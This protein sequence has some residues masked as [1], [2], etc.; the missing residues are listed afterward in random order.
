MKEN[1]NATMVAFTVLFST[2][3]F[4][5]TGSV[6]INTTTPD[7]SAVLDVESTTKGLLPP[8][9]TNDQMKAIVN[10]VD[11]LTVYNTTLKCLVTYINGSY[12][13]SYNAPVQAAP[14]APS[15]SSYTGFYNGITNEVSANNTAASY[16]TGVVFSA[17][18][19]CTTKEI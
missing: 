13:C 10:P 15:G 11:G 8:R 2:G 1:L 4:A 9:M 14:T 17:N 3:A 5:Q 7:P 6:G 18:T 19:T 16:T 12:N